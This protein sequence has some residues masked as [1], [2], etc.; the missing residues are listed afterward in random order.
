MFKNFSFVENIVRSAKIMQTENY[1][2]IYFREIFRFFR[3]ASSSRIINNFLY[4][5][6]IIENSSFLRYFSWIPPKML[7][8]QVKA[9]Y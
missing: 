6:H 4:S 5:I 7:I 9:S 1:Q 2:L 8:I 3:P